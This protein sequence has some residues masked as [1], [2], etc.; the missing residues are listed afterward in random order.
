MNIFQ[1]ILFPQYMAKAIIIGS[2]ISGIASALRLRAKGYEV[3]VFESNASPGGKMR[4]MQSKSYR[5]DTGPSLFTMPHL[6]DELFSLFGENPR[7]SFNYETLDIA[8]HYFYEDGSTFQAPSESGRLAKALAESHGEQAE[9]VTR[10]LD[11]SKHLYQI[12][13]PVFLENSLHKSSTYFSKTG[14]KGILNLWRLNMF[15][16]MNA[17]NSRWFSNP[18]T[19]QLFNRYATYNGSN[20]Y[21]APAT[22]NIIPHLEYGIGTYFPKGGMIDVT[23]SLFELGKR[24]G[25]HFHFNAGVESIIIQNG[26]AS[27]IRTNA[28]T[29]FADVTISNMDIYHTYSHLLKGEQMPESVKKVE[30]SSSALIFYWGIKHEF[31]QLGLHNIFFAKDYQNEFNTIF[32]ANNV[33]DDPTVYINITSKLKPDDAPAGCENWFVMVNVPPN[34]GQ[35]WDTIIANAKAS[36]L[37][38][39]SKQLGMDIGSMIETEDILD[40]RLIEKRTSSYRGALYG[41]SSNSRLAAFFRHPNF[42][43]SIDKLYFCGGSVH[44]GGGI[45][46]CL[47]SAEIVS[48]L[49]S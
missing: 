44:P 39:L 47:R 48:K 9:K 7:D 35:D 42:K 2:G 38:K 19:V 29:Y 10:F 21:K 43:G 5:F 40:P 1:F 18:K 8:C 28:G 4:E 6:V 34:N 46:L 20:P 37:T 26:K 31:K 41:S 15:S 27:G 11:K 14:L 45:P 24:Q 3:H 16:T 12:T 36:I 30:S 17:V 23:N 33:S 32:D 49:V 13:S 22:L 25:I